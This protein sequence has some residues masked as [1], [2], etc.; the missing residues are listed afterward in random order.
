MAAI[1]SGFWVFMQKKKSALDM[2]RKMRRKVRENHDFLPR[3][4]FHLKENLRNEKNTIF[5]SLI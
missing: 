1:I 4:N 3:K 2:P 5:R